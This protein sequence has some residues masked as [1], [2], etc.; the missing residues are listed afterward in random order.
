M[1]FEIRKEKFDTELGKL[2]K[3]YEVSLYA[4]N[5]V[6]QNGEVIPMVKVSDMQ[7]KKNEDKTKK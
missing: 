3:K 6:L 4:A 7:S 1:N 5:I 2:I